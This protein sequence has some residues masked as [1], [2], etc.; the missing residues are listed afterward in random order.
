MKTVR[1][2]EDGNYFTITNSGLCIQHKTE[3]L[4]Y[5]V[6]TKG[7]DFYRIK[8]PEGITTAE[9]RHELLIDIG[10]HSA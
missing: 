3:K 5:E 8:L 7:W 10:E 4:E 2:N 6:V 9:G 1:P